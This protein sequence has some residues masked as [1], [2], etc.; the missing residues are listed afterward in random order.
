MSTPVSPATIAAPQM[1]G[2][3]DKTKIIAYV[4]EELEVDVRPRLHR[5]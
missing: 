2:E 3:S 1:P 4:L 5:R